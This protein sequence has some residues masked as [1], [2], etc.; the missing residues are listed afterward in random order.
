MGW[1]PFGRRAT[2]DKSVETLLAEANVASPTPGGFRLPVEDVFAITGRG[3]VVTGRV[4]SGVG[5]LGLPVRIVRDGAQVATTRIT[6]IEAFRKTLESA[7][8]GDN[9]GLLLEGMSRDQLQA[10]DLVEG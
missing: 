8:A 1:W 7:Q 2:D 3:V 5:T 4:Q 10:G 6:G 9:V